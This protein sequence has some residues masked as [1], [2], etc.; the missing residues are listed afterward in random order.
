MLKKRVIAVLL[1]LIMIFASVNNV[2]WADVRVIEGIIGSGGDVSITI[3]E[4]EADEI[5]KLSLPL[6]DNSGGFVEPGVSRNRTL[7]IINE[8]EYTYEY[9]GYELLFGV[10]MKGYFYKIEKG[11][12]STRTIMLEKVIDVLCLR[13][14]YIDIILNF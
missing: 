2:V 1:I 11:L 14:Y 3:G 4:L 7:T 13:R 6:S 9:T 5:V 8:S 10:E 12:V